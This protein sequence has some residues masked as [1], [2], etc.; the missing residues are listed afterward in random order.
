MPIVTIDTGDPERIVIIEPTNDEGLICLRCG[1]RGGLGW[2][3]LN[4]TQVR[5][6]ANSLLSIAKSLPSRH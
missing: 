5:I 2:A 1:A 3:N 4:K 6:L